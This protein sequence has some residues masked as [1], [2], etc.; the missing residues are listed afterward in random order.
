MCCENSPEGGAKEQVIY[1]SPSQSE[2]LNDP[3]TTACFTGHRPEGIPFDIKFSDVNRGIVFSS[4]YLEIYEAY[5]RGYRTFI[6]G[7]ADGIDLLAGEAVEKLRD[8]YMNVRLVAVLPFKNQSGHY[9]DHYSTFRFTNLLHSANEVISI[10]DD[11]YTGCFYARNRYMVDNSSLLI[12]AVATR[13]GGS[14]YTV[15]YA[16]SKGIDIKTVNLKA[17]KKELGL[18]NKE[19]P[20]QTSIKF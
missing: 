18:K 20:D 11:Y 4:I 14:A 15:D 13:E 7:M 5:H 6:T 2:L 10:S 9:D 17:L 3:K 12:A 8:V 19:L 16:K 1:L